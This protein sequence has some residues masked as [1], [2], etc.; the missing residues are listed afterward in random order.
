MDDF[1]LIS[2]LGRGHFGKV[3]L[4]QHQKNRL[5]Y[6]IKALKKADIIS[7]DEVDSL[8]AEKRIFEAVNAVRHPFLVNLFSCF[9]TPVKIVK[10]KKLPPPFFKKW[11]KF[12]INLCF[13]CIGTCLFCDGI[14]FGGRLDGKVARFFHSLWW[15]FSH[16]MNDPSN[17]SIL[18]EI[19]DIFYKFCKQK[20][21]FFYC[22]LQFRHNCLN[23][24][25]YFYNHPQ[26]SYLDLS[27]HQ[28]RFLTFHQYFCIC[29]F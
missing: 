23:S 2:V 15:T 27:R 19:S 18:F 11:N 17:W 25:L 16:S 3:I 29:Q 12:V 8:L 9:Q 6:A 24:L 13:F 20:F 14:R 7:R 10:C 21:N 5:Y 1:K 4:V 26:I 22:H 28:L